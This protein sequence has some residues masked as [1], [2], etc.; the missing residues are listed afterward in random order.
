MFVSSPYSPLP[1]L[2]DYNSVWSAEW[3]GR[4][5]SDERH[6]KIPANALKQIKEARQLESHF[7]MRF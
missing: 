1:S 5:I 3:D 2:H 6:K 7:N 4:L